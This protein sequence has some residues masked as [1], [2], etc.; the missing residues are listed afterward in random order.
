MGNA[1]FYAKCVPVADD[2]HNEHLQ[3]LREEGKL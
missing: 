2:L 1:K 3:E